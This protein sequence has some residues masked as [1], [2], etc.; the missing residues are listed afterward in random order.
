MLIRVKSWI[1]L[2]AVGLAG[3]AEAGVYADAFAK[4]DKAAITQLRTQKDDIAARCTL[5]AIYAKKTDLSRAALYLDG[6]RDATLPEDISETVARAV[7]DV[8]KKLRESELSSI[9]I[10]IKPEGVTLTAKTSA[11]PDETFAI[12]TTIWVKAGTYDIEATDGTLHYKQTVT[13]GEF[14]RTSTLF[15]IDAKHELASPKVGKADFSE[16]N[17][18]EANTTGSPKAI[19][20]K[21]LIKGKYTG[22]A[23]GPAGNLE[24][25]ME[26]RRVERAPRDLW[27]GLR[28]GG[29]MF[30]DGATSA[31]VGGAVGATLR[32]ALSPRLFAAGRFDWSRRGGASIDVLGASAG[33]GLAVAKGMALIA[34]LRGDLRFG[35][36]MD[37][38]TVGAS[39]ALNL[40][41]ALP[42]TPITAG[43]RVEQGLTE[44]VP[45]ARDRAVLLELGVDWR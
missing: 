40:E 24:D 18:L 34:Q 15:E 21:S 45:G 22:E 27:L 17:L 38:N 42:S 30:D 19:K 7:R 37:K 26:V 14:S 12:P 9:V 11:L 41:L 6:C 29:G 36:V 20:H 39:A 44:I 31:R 33:A 3:N 43:L 28:L 2:V 5:G 8:T 16:E 23:T 13:V 4:S 1:A 35:D 25:P 10:S 32:Y